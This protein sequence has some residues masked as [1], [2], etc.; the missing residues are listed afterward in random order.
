MSRPIKFRPLMLLHQAGFTSINIGVSSTSIGWKLPMEGREAAW[1]LYVEIVTRTTIVDLDDDYGEDLTALS[2]VYSLFDTT[3]EVLRKYGV[4]SANLG[5]III[6]VLNE[7]V[8]PFTTKWT[9]KTYKEAINPE[10][11]NELRDLRHKLRGYTAILA[12]L[13]GVEDIAHASLPEVAPW[14]A[15]TKTSS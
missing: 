3:R 5:K 15:M 11:R 4:R 6:P 13:A 8:R 14:Q 10:F 1:E 2:S 7:T 9:G 12:H